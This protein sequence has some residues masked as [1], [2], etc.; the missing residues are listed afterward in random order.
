MKS[1]VGCFIGNKP[2]LEHEYP[3]IQT[4]LKKEIKNLMNQGAKCFYSGASRGFE[5]VAALTVLKLKE[6]EPN[7]KL[8]LVLLCQEHSR[9][10][11]K[12]DMEKHNQILGRAD[13]VIYTSEHYNS[14]CMQR[15][16]IYA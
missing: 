8:V 4:Y 6:K 13:K 5:T 1:Q 14:W 3:Q 12:Q 10:W 11:H 2:I 9:G 16:N 15:Q 7:L